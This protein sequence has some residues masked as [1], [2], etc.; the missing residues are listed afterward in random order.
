MAAST[1][2]VAARDVLASW[3]VLISL[4]VAPVLYSLY[5][6][7]ATIVAIKANLPFRWRMW[8]PFLTI[9]VLPLMSYG[10]LKFGEA[11]MDILK[12]VSCSLC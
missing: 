5:A 12:Y 1:V 3:K 11:G 10:A 2:K 6:V 9:A 8:T 7:L 4:G